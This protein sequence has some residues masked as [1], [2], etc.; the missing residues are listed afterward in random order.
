V[1]GQ[2]HVAGEVL[3]ELLELCAIGKR[4]VPEQVSDFFESRLL[5][6]IADLV[7]AVDESAGEAVNEADL[8]LG[9]DDAL[10]AGAG[11]GLGGGGSG[12]GSGG[13]LGHAG[14]R[15]IGLGDTCF[16]DTRGE[17]ADRGR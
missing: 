16:A 11:R 17:H 4:A 3:L 14:P 10:E 9:G 2:R 15:G 5:D 8:A 6:E 7:A 1:I 12:G 13:G